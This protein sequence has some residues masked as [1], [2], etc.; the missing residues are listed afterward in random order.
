MKEIDKITLEHVL[1]RR[2]YENAKILEETEFMQ[3][4]EEGRYLLKKFIEKLDEIDAL[5]KGDL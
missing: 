1:Y 4:F 2:C 5:N 3:R